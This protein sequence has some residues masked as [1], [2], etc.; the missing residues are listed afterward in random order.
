VWQAVLPLYF[1]RYDP[2]LAASAF[3]QCSFS[4]AAAECSDALF[5]GYNVAPRLGGIHAPTLVIVG[6]D[7][8]VCPPSQASRLQ[9]G[10]PMAKQTT[11]AACGHFPFIERPAAFIM[12]VQSWLDEV[13]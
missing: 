13:S 4:A 8:F 5:A 12:A 10:L 2:V 1:H 9:T 6:D 11:I 7:D 3:A